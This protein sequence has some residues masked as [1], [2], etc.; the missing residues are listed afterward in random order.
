MMYSKTTSLTPINLITM[1]DG[2]VNTLSTIN[3]MLSKLL[4]LFDPDQYNIPKSKGTFQ[5]HKT[6]HG[7]P[8]PGCTSTSAE[9]LGTCWTVL[10]LGYN[11][12]DMFLTLNPWSTMP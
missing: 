8:Q 3:L 4:P 6:G 2:G 9:L 1:R 12:H 11:P 7:F 5:L 10:T